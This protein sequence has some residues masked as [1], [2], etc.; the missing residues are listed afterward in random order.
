MGIPRGHGAALALLGF[1]VAGCEEDDWTTDLTVE[2]R[3][4]GTSPAFVYVHFKVDWQANNEG[5]DEGDD[6][7]VVHPG[8]TWSRTYLSAA[9]VNVE[10]R[11]STDNLVLFS[12]SLRQKD[13]G[14]VDGRWAI[15]VYP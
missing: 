11:R 2:I 13:F 8:E 1:L 9:Q 7:G 12:D 5:D 14:D 6:A 3:N 10:V 15:V 4:E